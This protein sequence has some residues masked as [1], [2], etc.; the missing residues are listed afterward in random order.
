MKARTAL[1]CVAGFLAISGIGGSIF[2][3]THEP[4]NQGFAQYPNITLLHVLPGAL[5]LL[6]APFQFSKKI[7]S[8]SLNTHRWSGRILVSIGLVV[9]AAAMFLGLVV[10]YSGVPEQIVIG[11]FGTLFLFSLVRGF[12]YARA[13]QIGLHREWMIRA[14]TIGLS[15]ATMRLIFIPA[16]IIVGDPT[17]Q[18]TESLSIIAF[19]IAFILHSG[20]AEFWIRYT[21]LVTPKPVP[22]TVS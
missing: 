4:N 2:F 20:F 21:R 5:Y 3:F 1:S 18:V 10:P 19:T 22:A 14:F 17:R 8:K 13:K 6:L 16:L 12:T 15:I 11:F 7:R 9:G